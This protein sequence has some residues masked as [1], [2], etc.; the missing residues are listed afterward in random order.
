MADDYSRQKEFRSN[1]IPGVAGVTRIVPPPLRP[2][3]DVTP[4]TYRSE[5]DPLSHVVLVGLLSAL[6]VVFVLGK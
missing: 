5:P 2:S 1:Q 6:L 3:D 4:N